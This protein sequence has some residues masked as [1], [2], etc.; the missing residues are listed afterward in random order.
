MDALFSKDIIKMLINNAYK[1]G[2]NALVNLIKGRPAYARYVKKITITENDDLYILGNML[3]LKSLDCSGINITDT[4]LSRFN[5]LKSLT[6]MNCHNL[7][8]MPLLPRLKILNCAGSLNITNISNASHVE[9]LAI[10]SCNNITDISTL[11]I[12]KYVMYSPVS[13]G[14]VDIQYPPQPLTKIPSLMR[15]A[16]ISNENM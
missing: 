4:Q 16:Y 14:G 10:V 8:V 12:L 3:K 9:K 5:R 7:R 6:C 11:H 1:E 13:E 2:G 15:D